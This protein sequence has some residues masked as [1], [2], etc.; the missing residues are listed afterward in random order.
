MV[1]ARGLTEEQI[2]DIQSWVAGGMPE[3]DQSME[4][5]EM[6]PTDPFVMS[7]QFEPPSPYTPDASLGT[8]DYHCFVLN[9][10]L[11]VD[12]AVTALNIIPGDRRVVHHVLLY[13]VDT[14]DQAQL[15]TLVAGGS[16]GGYTCFGGSGINSASIIGGWVP[17][18]QATMF[19][20]GTGVVVKAGTMI[21]M[22]VHYN[23]LVVQHTTDQTTA[24]L[25]YAASSTDVTPA[26]IVPMYND[27]FSVAP[28]R[29]RP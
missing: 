3:G 19:P 11:S 1:G 10:N 21:V 13:G 15:S 20:K 5:S 27:T 28:A 2:S 9:P 29:C 6:P 22:Q 23:L 25:E 8:D 18:T 14:A 4:P 24:Q 16:G 17:G 7:A 12:T 26:Y